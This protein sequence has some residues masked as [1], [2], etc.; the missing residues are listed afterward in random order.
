MENIGQYVKVFIGT[1][2]YEGKILD[3]DEQ[4]YLINDRDGKIRIPKSLAVLM[5]GGRF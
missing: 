4:T 3:E 5:F 1:M 2:K